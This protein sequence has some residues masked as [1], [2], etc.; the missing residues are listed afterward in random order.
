MTGTG[1]AVGEGSDE[2]ESGHCQLWR[3]LSWLKE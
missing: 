2:Y 1:K 3:G